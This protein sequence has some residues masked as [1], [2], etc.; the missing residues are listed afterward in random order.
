M[1]TAE[2]RQE[3]LQSIDSMRDE[4]VETVSQLVRIRSV[5]PG[6]PGTNYEEELGGETQ[7]NQFLAEIHRQMDL[8]IDMWEE[9]K[10]RTNL[11]GIWK[12]TG[13]G[14]S[15]IHNGHIDTVPLGRVDAWKSGDPLSGKVEGGKIYG[16]GSCDM[17][18]PVVS[19]MFAIQA[20]QRAGVK[21]AG[22]VIL[23]STVG[24]ENMDSAKI[25]AGSMVKRGHKAD[26]A[27]VSEPSAPP[28]PL[29][30]VP[31]SPGLWWVSVSVEGKASH[32]ATRGE[33]IRAGGMGE[34]VAVSAIDKGVFLLEAIR[35]FEDQWGLTKKHPLFKPGHFTLLP[36]VISGAPHGVQV[37]FF[38][39]DY[40]TIEYCI[41]HHP[42]EDAEKIK[43]EFTRFVH[44]AAELDPWLREHPP[45]LDWKV[46][47]P[48]FNVEV[49][50]PICQAVVKAHQ[51]AV[52]GTKLE[53]PAK[54]AGFYAV[55]DAAFL[56]RD[57]VPAIVYG[58]GSLL[59]AHAADEYVEIEELI[60][61]TK[62]YALL[63]I[64]WCGTG[65]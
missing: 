56:H 39:P 23:S 16:R 7:A 38:I 54:V 4:I 42:D 9:E 45:Q 30:V 27:V 52:A 43:E 36:G 35:K 3:I 6:Y 64:D 50:H 40:C 18:G 63:T 53:G 49:D 25:G 2:Q 48:P 32:A 57:G 20:L 28:Y 13:G 31:T 26:A 24:E 51:E 41:W 60:A 58:P 55:C 8:D 65:R 19:Q 1:A 29:A 15:L 59:V 46:H 44:R 34:A 14:K 12:G 11:V 21:L 33:T 47:W 62:T 37:P 10:G 61:A 17:K 22:D 5:N